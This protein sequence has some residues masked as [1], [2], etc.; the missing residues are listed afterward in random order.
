MVDVNKLDE[1]L[2]DADSEQL[3]YI[4]DT[5]KDLYSAEELAYILKLK[6]KR[7]QEEEGEEKALHAKAEEYLPKEIN[8]PKCDGPNDFHDDVCRF[9]G[10]K[11]N[12][13]EYYNRAHNMALGVD[14]DEDSDERLDDEE[15]RSFL[16]QYVISFLIPLVGWIMGG[17]FLTRKDPEEHDA[18]TICIILGIAS[19]V[20]AG[21]IYYFT[22]GS[23]INTI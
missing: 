8:C 20:L 16:A 12:K 4:Y 23:A 14:D 21:L 6:A 2:G 9:C 17:I 5:Q 19:G 18:G 15:R 11:L 13:A 3:Q 1:E 22:I 10:A 7:I